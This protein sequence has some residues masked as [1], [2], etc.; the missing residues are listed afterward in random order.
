MEWRIDITERKNMEVE[1]RQHRGQ[2]EELVKNRTLELEEQANK[3]KESQAALSFLLDDV[4]ESREELLA[5]NREIKKLSQALEQSPTSIIITDIKGKIEYVNRQFL[6]TSGYLE[7]EI[8]GKN[9]RIQNSGV[10]SK[11]FFTKLW[12]TIMSGKNWYGEICNKKKTGELHWEYTSIS[13]LR[14]S[15]QKIINFIAV[16]EDITERKEIE[17][18]LKEYTE[19][20][21][22]FNKVM[23][24]R[25]L[26]I[27]EM[28]EEV[29]AL[30]QEFGKDIK[31]PPMW[32]DR[33][34]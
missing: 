12:K 3:I 34:V 30:Y 20:L 1:L 14:N 23:V 8:I 7:D 4:N 29:N 17:Q 28:K 21:E 31:Y 22:L 33:P 27:I 5:S 13:P 10:H 6:N 18:K 16:K 32:N 24:D 9:P 2:L 15:N 25:E 19:E 26:K 11:E